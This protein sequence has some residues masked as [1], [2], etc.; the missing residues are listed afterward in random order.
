MKTREKKDV[1]PANNALYNC[2]PQVLTKVPEDFVYTVRVLS[3]MGY[4][5]VNLNLG[6]PVPTVTTK[7]KG[8]AML[9]NTDAL[10]RFFD[11]TFELMESEHLST[12]I[13]V[14]SRIGVSSTDEAIPIY[15]VF[16]RYPIREVI[17]HPRT[18]KEMY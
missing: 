15:E 16:N 1:A 2:I 5:E 17:V 8:S 18:T 11:R 7:G 3:E 9:G 13:S 14:K 10:D 12:G 4:T 6:C